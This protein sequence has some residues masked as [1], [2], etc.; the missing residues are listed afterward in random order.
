M[1]WWALLIILLLIVIDQVIKIWVKTNMTIGEQIVITDWF[2]IYF[3]ENNGMAY[4][5][6]FFNKLLL[7]SFRIV[8]VTLIGIY[9]YRAIKKG[10]NFGYLLCLSLIF[11]GAIGNIFDSLFY[12]QIFTESTPWQVAQFTT[13]G[14]GYTDVLYG[15]VVD[16]FYF[17]LWTWP[18]WLPFLGGQI[19]FSPI[20]NFADSCIT[21]GVFLLIIFFR[22]ELENVMITL[23]EGTR[24]ESWMKEKEDVKSEITN[25][26]K[27]NEE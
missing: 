7:S 5:I 2:K 11:A 10:I 4:G 12:G 25:S 14:E 15:K 18:D 27:S 24:F 23:T 22:K 8:A 9:I 26:E 13:F 1:G 17:P 16:M 6:T 21:V 19:F 20:F 3:I